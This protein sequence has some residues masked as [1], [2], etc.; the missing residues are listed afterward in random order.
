[1]FFLLKAFTHSKLL[2]NVYSSAQQAYRGMIINKRHQSILVHG[3]SNIHTKREIVREVMSYLSEN[4]SP[5]QQDKVLNL[6]SGSITIPSFVDRLVALTNMVEFFCSSSD[7]QFEK[8]TVMYNLEF[9]LGGRII[10]INSQVSVYD[11]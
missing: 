5:K 6:P 2:P 7:M 1:M 11:T 8:S 4:T 9:D 10:G 3:Q